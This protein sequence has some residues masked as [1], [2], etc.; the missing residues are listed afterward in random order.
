MSKQTPEIGILTKL[1]LLVLLFAL[2]AS[3]VEAIPYLLDGFQN[4]RI[5]MLEEP[6][7][8]T[9][10]LDVS[11]CQPNKPEL[12][13][14]LKISYRA[15]LPSDFGAA[16]VTLITTLLDNG[17]LSYTIRLSQ[18]SKGRILHKDSKSEFAVYQQKY[19]N[20]EGVHSNLEWG[21]N[22]FHDYVWA[23]R[24]RLLD[25]TGK[26]IEGSCVPGDRFDDSEQSVLKASGRIF[27]DKAEFAS[28]KI[29]KWQICL[30]K[31]YDESRHPIVT[32]SG[33]FAGYDSTEQH[34]PDDS[35]LQWI[36]LQG[37]QGD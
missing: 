30:I 31:D 17:E 1:T 10:S 5:R 3:K 20:C 29:A 6:E 27:F 14:Q 8:S 4:L 13:Q 22:W 24:V 25:D 15:D 11:S 34:Y 9:D 37:C 35:K 7:P 23:I 19:L 28:A 16:A 21:D 33:K 26:F 12:V 32:C 2:C 36:D 18:S